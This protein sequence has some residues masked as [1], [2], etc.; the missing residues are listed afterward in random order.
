MVRR[1]TICLLNSNINVINRVVV[2]TC[3]MSTHT[4]QSSL[5]ENIN[6]PKTVCALLYSKIAIIDAEKN[7]TRNV[8]LTQHI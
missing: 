5:K 4:M 1:R 3:G 2:V 7:K 8:K 6:K